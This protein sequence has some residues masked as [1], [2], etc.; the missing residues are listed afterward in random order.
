MSTSDDAAQPAR[1]ASDPGA[2]ASAPGPVLVPPEHVPAVSAEA[3]VDGA[4][5]GAGSGDA[6]EVERRY[7]STIGGAFY[8]LAFLVVVVGL[9]LVAVGQ[10]RT[11]IRTF[12][13]AMLFAAAVRLLLKPRD[14]GMLA[15][16]NKPVDVGILVTLGAVVIWLATSIP[17]QP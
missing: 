10:W 11:G 4:T 8:L 16:R 13:A 3:L 17:D 6:A 12:G 14:A 9:V 7:P 2:G 15:V 1:P 5:A